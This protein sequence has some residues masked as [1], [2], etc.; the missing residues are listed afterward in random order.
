M[1]V[2]AKSFLSSVNC[3]HK[4]RGTLHDQL[5]SNIVSFPLQHQMSL[6]HQVSTCKYVRFYPAVLI[7][8]YQRLVILAGYVHM[9]V[10]QSYVWIEEH[11]DSRVTYLTCK[12][13]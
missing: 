8:F 7:N 4:R 13:D 2:W 11:Q 5:S 10:S 1:R 3:C 9:F 12:S 6:V